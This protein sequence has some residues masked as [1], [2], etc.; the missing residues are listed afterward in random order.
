MDS[1]FPYLDVL[2][3]SIDSNNSFTDYLSN[4]SSND[5][6]LDPYH[7]ESSFPLSAPLSQTLACDINRLENLRGSNDID[8]LGNC[9]IHEFNSKVVKSNNKILIFQV[10]C[11]SLQKNFS[12][13]KA[14]VNNSVSKPDIM[15]LSETWLDVS[16]ADLYQLDGYSLVLEPRKKGKGGGVGIYISNKLSYTTNRSILLKRQIASFECLVVEFNSILTN[17]LM[18]ACVYRPPSSSISDFHDEF[19]SVFNDITLASKNISLIVA[20]D[21][22]LDLMMSMSTP[23]ISNFLISLYSLNLYPTISSYTR[24][25]D[26]HSS[27]LDN[28]FVS[29]EL[30]VEQSGVI[31]D[32]I[33]DHF[34][35]FITVTSEAV[36]NITPSI[37]SE[38]SIRHLTKRNFTKFRCL[39]LDTDWNHFN[40]YLNYMHTYTNLSSSDLYDLFFDKFFNIFNIAFPSLSS[41][42]NKRNT[43]KS[44]DPWMTPDLLKACRIKSKLLKTY[45]RFKNTVAKTKYKN[46]AKKL[47]LDIRNAEKTYY[48]RNFHNHCS[49]KDL[50]KNIN[51][52]IKPSSSKNVQTTFISNGSKIDDPVQ[53][54]HE[55]N[56]FFTNIGSD[57]AKSLP[58]SPDSPTV[59]LKDKN[60]A[61]IFMTP[62]D[63]HEIKNILKKLKQ[64]TG[65]GLDSLPPAAVKAAANFITPTLVLLIN[66]SFSDG[67]FPSALKQAKVTPIFKDQDQKLFSNYRP[68]SV[69]NVLSK[70]FENVIKN[71]FTCF[72]NKHSILHN[73]QFGF[74]KG[75]STSMPIIKL[76][77]KITENIDSKLYSV[78]IFLDFKK[79][80]DSLDHSVLL[81]KLEHY[82]IRGIALT[83]IKNY[84]TDRTQSVCYNN[85]ISTPQTI[86]T[87]VPQ[88]S[89][90]GPL[91]FLVFINDIVYSS[92]IAQFLLYA[93]DTTSLYTGSDLAALFTVINSDLLKISYW[94]NVNKISINYNKTKYTIFSPKQMAFNS[95]INLKCKVHIDSTII[96]EVNDFKFL[97]VIIDNKLTW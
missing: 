80:F 28:I 97:G 18:I 96:D 27:I 52:L 3:I 88:G 41:T 24:V 84:L 69:L 57:I 92:D 4:S 47:K 95:P 26:T 19:S 67:I 25:T 82:G 51:Q 5:S 11:R 45:K 17:S 61:S 8:Y 12:K 48:S 77:D 32:D 83:L 70:V 90:L 13:L 85:T 68:I 1:N 46:Y 64:N 94:C 66:F 14:L 16:L 20:G 42:V 71:R 50:W 59:F 44:N 65:P 38:K 62:T 93:D 29:S 36:T 40:A 6:L 22:N 37:T 9:S 78:A 39:L 7:A 76:I 91:L 63:E 43:D 75:C 21:F 87:G 33:S 49:V 10:N 31:A 53:I 73:N 23:Q 54:V 35:T 79:A 2:N 34:P 81:T 86:I 15:C 56:N 74:T 89:I 55:F 72:L 60:K 30:S 58:L